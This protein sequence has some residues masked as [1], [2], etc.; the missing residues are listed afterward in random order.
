[1][2]ALVDPSSCSAPG[3]LHVCD[4]AAVPA[5]QHLHARVPQVVHAHSP[6][7][8]ARRKDVTHDRHRDA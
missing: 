8:R 3:E 4:A 6:V 2:P 7:E 1:M 5:Q